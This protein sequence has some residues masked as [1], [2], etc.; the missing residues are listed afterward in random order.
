MCVASRPK[1]KRSSQG[2]GRNFKIEAESGSVYMSIKG[3][4][5][6]PSRTRLRH[7]WA[8]RA[9]AILLA[10]VVFAS[11]AD[12]QQFTAGEKG[13]V[14]GKI[15]AR[16]GAAVEV[17]EAKTGSLAMVLITENTRIL[18]TK[19]KVVFRRHEEMDVTT[20]VP[21]LTIDAQGMGD[22]S[23]LLEASRITFSPDEFAIQVAEE[24]QIL[25]DRSAAT[26]AQ[27]TADDAVAAAGAA[28]ASADQATTSAGQAGATAQVAGTLAL[29]GAAAA[30]MLNQRV[31]DLDDYRT[32]AEAIIYDP[33]GK[34]TLDTS[35]KAD[36][37]LLAARALST[38]GYLIE[39]AGYAS[40]TGS[41]A[42]N[43][44]LSEDRAAAVAQYLR[45]EGDIPLR[46][47][48]APVG[49][50][51]TPPYATSDDP[52]GPA[53]DQRVDVKLIVNKGLGGM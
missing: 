39:I 24:Q 6:K 22:A 43:Q 13:T 12:A 28:Q 19:S 41:K 36:L 27:S 15:V 8:Q 21:G 47:I 25:A 18:R 2:C 50:G 45:S 31:S 23:G 42:S 26:Q 29:I 5:V 32:V 17:Q 44:Q 34:Y 9:C 14:K 16:R 30:G 35:A 53:L 7:D 38:D 1:V 4:A 51:Y 11:L 3:V 48:V 40:R 37:D 52:R 10:G 46:R 20:M 49:Y 33:P